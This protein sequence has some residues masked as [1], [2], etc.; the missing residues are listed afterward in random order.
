YGALASNEAVTTWLA[1]F[2]V[3]GPSSTSNSS[4]SA[5][6][7]SVGR[8]WPGFAASYAAL[9]F[10]SICFCAASSVWVAVAILL[11]LCR[12]R[13]KTPPYGSGGA[14]RSAVG[15]EEGQRDVLAVDHAVPVGGQPQVRQRGGTAEGLVADV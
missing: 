12:L 11:L 1:T 10:A 2:M 8:S 5:T 7:P 13:M 6:T 15:D 4:P 3:R 14:L 9:M